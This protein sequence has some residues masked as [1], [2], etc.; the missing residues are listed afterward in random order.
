MKKNLAM[1]A[2]AFSAL[3]SSCGPSAEEKMAQ[4]QREKDSIAAAEAA[5]KAAEEASLMMAADSS[6]G[7]TTITVDTVTAP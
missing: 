7:D 4:E 5:I 1:M 2:L 3:L 6:T